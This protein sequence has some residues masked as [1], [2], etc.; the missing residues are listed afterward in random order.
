M[1]VKA[2]S[3]LK[4]LSWNLNESHLSNQYDPTNM[5]KSRGLPTSMGESHLSNQYDPTN[6]NESHLFNQSEPTNMNESHVA[7]LQT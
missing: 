6:M 5:N 4:L 7:N 3:V 2:P 1:W